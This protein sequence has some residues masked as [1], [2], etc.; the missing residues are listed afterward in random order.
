MFAMG[1][2]TSYEDKRGEE[3]GLFSRINNFNITNFIYQVEKKILTY[4][5]TF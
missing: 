1:Q 3:E 5:L 2:I 4:L